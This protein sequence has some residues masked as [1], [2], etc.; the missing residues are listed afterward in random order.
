MSVVSRYLDTSVAGRYLV[1]APESDRVLPLFVGFHGYG[2]D[3]ADALTLLRT[4][5][6]DLPCCLCSIEALHPFYAR[7]G[8]VGMSWMTS[9]DRERRIGENLRYV[10]AVIDELHADYSLDDTL[11][12]HGFSQGAAMAARVAIHGT[13]IPS[14]LMLLGGGIPDELPLSARRCPVH[15]A[16]GRRDRIYRAEQF[17]ADLERMQDAGML[18]E[19]CVYEGGHSPEGE[20]ADSASAFVRNCIV[21]G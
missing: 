5:V 11:V 16:R 9:R 13:R 6:G 17:S 8:E 2:Q 15:L 4:L 20:Y 21:G 14:G 3:A 12:L 1:V 18:H 7:G 19:A 10:D